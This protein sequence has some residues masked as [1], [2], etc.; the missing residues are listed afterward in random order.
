MSNQIDAIKC[1]LAEIGQHIVNTGYSFATMTE[2]VSA[3]LDL[4][5]LVAGD[6]HQ[7]ENATLTGGLLA[8]IGRGGEHSPPDGQGGAA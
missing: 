4:H 1:Q 8:N 6:L 2:F 5:D 3:I 7:R